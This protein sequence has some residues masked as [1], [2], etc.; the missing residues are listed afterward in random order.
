[1]TIKAILLDL[2][3]TLVDTSAIAE[4][5]DTRKWGYIGRQLHL[6]QAVD[7]IT[8]FISEMQLTCRMGVVTSSPGR[9]A[10]QVIQYHQLGVP[11]LVA[12]GHTRRHKPSPEPLLLAT[13]LL[14]VRSGEVIAVGDQ[15]EDVLA[16]QAAGILSIAVTWGDC[17]ITDLRS[18]NPTHLV[19]SPEML[20]AIVRSILTVQ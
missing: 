9:Y 4:L 5:R 10:N 20:L 11:I 14:D 15:V 7:G 17:S 1:M 6:T 16:A 2:D 18:V 3:G 13:R 19:D 8:R 12:Y